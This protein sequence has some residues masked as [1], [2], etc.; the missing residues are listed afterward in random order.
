MKREELIEGYATK[1][2]VTKKSTAEMFNC[3]I[4]Y[5]IEKLKEGEEIYLTGFCK[6]GTYLK[7]SKKGRNFHTG[8]LVDLPPRVTPY[9]KFSESLKE[10]LKDSTLIVDVSKDDSQNDVAYEDSPEEWTGMNDFD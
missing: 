2:G 9:C 8:E 4:E 1:Y 5:F 7:K 3:V 10:E 6:L